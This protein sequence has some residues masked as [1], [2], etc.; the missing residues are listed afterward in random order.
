M[1]RRLETPEDFPGQQRVVWRRE[2]QRL[3][4]AAIAGAL[5]PPMVLTL[6]IWPPK[7]WLPGLE[8]DWRLTVLIVGAV[9]TPVGL[10]L[11]ARERERNGRPS[12]RLG[13]VWRFMFYGGLLA[14]ALGAMLALVHAVQ[15][16]LSAASLGE[17]LG[18]SETSLLIY[19]VGG[20]P[21]AVL[22]GV[23]YALWAGLCV[24]FI[25]FA[26]QPEVRNRLGVM[27]DPAGE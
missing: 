12:T 21:F 11:L 3:V 22:I 5:W 26:P 15:Q 20:L 16:W 13:V 17:G 4:L 8:M 10:W 27:R 2:P 19:G 23:A 18:G 1:I 6:L 14:A 9:G 24:A 7:N 25:A